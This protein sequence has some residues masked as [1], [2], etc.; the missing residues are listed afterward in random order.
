[1]AIFLTLK[2]NVCFKCGLFSITEANVRRGR[3]LDRK[4]GRKVLLAVRLLSNVRGFFRRIVRSFRIVW[5]VFR[6]VWGLFSIAGG[7]VRWVRGSFRIVRGR[8]RHVRGSFSRAGGF[9]NFVLRNCFRKTEIGNSKLAIK[10][11]V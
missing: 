7:N 1:M 2:E 4:A 10:N 11:I 3:G 6:G 5:G 9:F 8:F